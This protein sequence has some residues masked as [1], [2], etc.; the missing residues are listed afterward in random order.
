VVHYVP[1]VSRVHSRTEAGSSP[2]LTFGVPL[3]DDAWLAIMVD[4]AKTLPMANPLSAALMA[5]MVDE[6]PTPSQVCLRL[7]WSGQCVAHVVNTYR[8]L[9]GFLSARICRR[10]LIC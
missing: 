2:F 8:P 3:V 7:Q 9:T 1:Y 10:R 4:L 6:L 5:V